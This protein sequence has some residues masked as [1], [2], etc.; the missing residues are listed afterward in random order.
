MR[1]RVA[2]DA[3]DLA[4]PVLALRADNPKRG[5]VWIAIGVVAGVTA[6]GVW[7]ALRL[8]RA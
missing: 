2:G 8:S 3:L 7:D 6:P 5:N 1:A 4:T